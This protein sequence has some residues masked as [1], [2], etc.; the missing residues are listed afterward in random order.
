MQ[1]PKIPS[2]TPRFNVLSL[3]T[4]NL[5]HCITK[6]ILPRLR[7]NADSFESFVPC[8]S[9]T[10]KKTLAPAIVGNT[11]SVYI[12]PLPGCKSAVN[13]AMPNHYYMFMFL[14]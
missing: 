12:E 14:Y 10:A 3:E 4:W 1:I 7:S 11:N 2:Y 5:K 9:L 8:N 6:N 13:L